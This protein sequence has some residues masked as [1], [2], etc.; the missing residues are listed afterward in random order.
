MN[1]EKRPKVGVGV[2]LIRNRKVLFGKRKNSYGKGSWCFPG[3]HLEFGESWEECARRETLEETG[4]E[5]KNVRFVTTTN[6]FFS[7]ENKHYITILMLA[8]YVSG[9]ARLMEPEKCEEWQW[10]KWND[11]PSPL[12]IPQQNLNKQ[13]F[14][15]F[16][17]I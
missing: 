12:F 13:K 9:E 2:C 5:I 17:K 3:G 14:D 6:D 15:P 4:L 8:E 7:E 11:Q 16:E 10:F 1:Q